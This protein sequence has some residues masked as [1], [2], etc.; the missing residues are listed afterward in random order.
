DMLVTQIEQ[1]MQREKRIGFEVLIETALGHANVEAIAQSS[2]RLEAL[3]FGSGDFAAS[4]R[5]R[6][7]VIGGLHPDYGVLTDKDASGHRA[8]QLDGRL[9]DLASIRMA[10]NVLRTAEAIEAAK[11]KGT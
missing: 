6:T 11:R 9:I 5:A 2:R 4:T 8:V 1:A 10:Q 3:T 7:T